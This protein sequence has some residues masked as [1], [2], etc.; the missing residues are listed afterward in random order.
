MGDVVGHDLQAAAAMGQLRNALRA[1]AA[2]GDAP[3]IVLERLNRLCVQQGLGD[4]ATVLYGV[5]DPVAGRLRLASAGHYP[6]L[7][8]SEHDRCFLDTEPRPP[9]GAVREVKYTSSVHDLPADSL[10]L[11]YTDG[12]VERGGTDVEE[13]L[14]RLR[15]L[16]GPLSDDGLEVVCDQILT[17]ML[18]EG[19]PDDVALLAV[20]TQA[21]LGADMELMW[22]AEAERLGSLRRVLDRWLVEVGANEEEV[23]DVTVACS[24][25]VTNAIE[26]AYGPGRADVGILFHAQHGVVT[27]T[28]RDWGQWREARGRDRGRGLS[29]MSALMDEVDVNHAA[30]GTRVTMT[31]SLACRKA[32]PAL[33]ELG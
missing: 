24:E 27:I 29:L 20:A 9:I 30:T 17:G 16:V 19:Q 4:M 31:R 14:A 18:G 26:H 25:A 5:L 6:P 28:V 8:V 10:L 32:S 21:V 2:D 33:A 11:L 1:C 3:E 15:A 13:G 7:L 22:P 12:L 23:Y